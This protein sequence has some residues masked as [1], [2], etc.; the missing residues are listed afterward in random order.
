MGQRRKGW[1]KV[2]PDH[3]DATSGI[4]FCISRFNRQTRLLTESTKA[5]T[6]LDVSRKDAHG[7]AG[8]LR[9]TN[10]STI[11]IEQQRLIYYQHSRLDSPNLP[12]MLVPV[13]SSIIVLQKK[14]GGSFVQIIRKRCVNGDQ[15][16]SSR[17]PIRNCL[18][19]ERTVMQN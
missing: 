11:A 13:R 14:K 6:C 12:N 19:P 17:L 15:R 2:E 5:S 10:N 18:L 7:A 8:P 4:L 16:T 9:Y 3:R 1:N